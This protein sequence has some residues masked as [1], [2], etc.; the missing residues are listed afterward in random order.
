MN[1]NHNKLFLF[2]FLLLT[3]CR[4]ESPEDRLIS[5]IE[6][7]YANLY[8]NNEP[9]KRAVIQDLRNYFK[10]HKLNDETIEEVRLKLN[11]I[12]DGHVVLYDD[13][14][15]KNTVYVSGAKFVIGSEILESCID[16]N[17]VIP[18][19]KYQIMEVNK[20][21]YTEFI[22]LSKNEVSASSEWGRQY[23]VSRLL[24]RKSNNTETSLKLKDINGKIIT[25]K[26]MWK[27]LENKNPPCVTGQRIAPDIFKVHVANLWCDESNGDDWSRQQIVDNFKLQFDT[28]MNEANE[29]DRII[30]ELRENGGG[31]D[32]E[33]KYVI[34]A[35]IE[36]Q[37]LLYHFKY[38]FKTHPGKLKWITD[39]LPFELPLW[40][41]EE[42]EYTNL[43]HKPKKTFYKNKMATII[44]SGCF[45]SCETIVSI[46][47]NEKRSLVIGSLTHGGSGDPV[48]FD[49][50]N[51]HYSINLPTCVNWQVPGVVYEGVGVHPN[52]TA[53][54]NP[55]I[56][57]D[58][59][60]NLAIDLTR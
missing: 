7:K 44:S 45:S 24:S 18:K 54:Q 51:T 36:K 6:Q 34:N 13:R 32:E 15:E 43:V 39:Y 3:A 12:N 27:L 11:G 41:E 14:K 40:T 47:K 25:T 49:I 52:I 50:K 2:L 37:V 23:R 42:Y 17:P 5:Y 1:L 56:K 53:Y 22:K 35:F 59:V 31:G 26:L 58:N 9:H 48:I 38:L 20:L 10:T 46:L 28:V 30:L 55:N 29:K 60:L 21:P 8:Y 16:C 33:V 57:E 4:S 19:S